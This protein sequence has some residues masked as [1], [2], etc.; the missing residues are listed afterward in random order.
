LMQRVVGADLKDLGG[1][2]DALF[3]RGKNRKPKE[4][5]PSSTAA[6]SPAPTASL[7]APQSPLP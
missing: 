3:G 6:P 1:V 4:A 7:T 2:I 5:T